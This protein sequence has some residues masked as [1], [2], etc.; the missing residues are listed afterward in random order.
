MLK[1]QLQIEACVETV[2]DQL[3]E[4]NLK[5]CSPRKVSLLSSKYVQNRMEFAKQHLD[6]WPVS[7][8]RNILF[9]DASK[10]VLCMVEKN[11]F[12]MLDTATYS[13]I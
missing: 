8:W 3:R 7:N 5:A 9:T 1:N 11:L 13:R 6:Y 2:R 4:N 10:I 12:R